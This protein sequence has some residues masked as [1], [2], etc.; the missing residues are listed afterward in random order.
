MATAIFISAPSLSSLFPV[1]SSI[2]K[3]RQTDESSQEPKGYT[4]VSN[5]RK[6]LYL[7]S[8]K[9]LPRLLGGS[10]ATNENLS[11]NFGNLAAKT[12]SHRLYKF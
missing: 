7:G 9:A 3:I 4:P 10:V 8:R 6:F 2:P 5:S 12:P 1:Q 11:G